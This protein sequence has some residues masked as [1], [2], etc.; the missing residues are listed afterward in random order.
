MKKSVVV[1]GNFDGV[2]LGHQALIEHAR[3][4]ADVNNCTLSIVTFEPHPRTF[5]Q[6]EASP[7]RLTPAPIKK[8]ILSQYCDHYHALDFNQDMVSKTA[9]RFIQDI[10]VDLCHAAYVVVGADFRFGKDRAGSLETLKSD[11]RFETVAYDLKEIGGEAISSSR[12]RDHLKKAE[13]QQAQALLG[14]VWIIES[15]VIH[16]DKRGR[17]LG[18]PTANM[19]FGDTLVPS[20]GVYTVKVRIKGEREWRHGAANIGIRPMFESREPLLEVYIFD[21]NDDLYGQILE[22]EPVQKIRDEM[23]FDNLHDLK[24]QMKNDCIIAKE[25][26]HNA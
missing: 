5:F 14:R 23:K 22:V 12:I 9:E 19:R 18:Y 2:H 21:F 1:I 26:L 16:G 6:A 3:G 24:G 7:F 4:I 10:I 13:L 8:D 15:E 17:E 11:N 20:H 25:I